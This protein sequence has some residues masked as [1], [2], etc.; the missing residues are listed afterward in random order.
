[1]LHGVFMHECRN[2]NKIMYIHYIYT[3]VLIYSTVT[4]TV[5]RIRMYVCTYIYVCTYVCMH[6]YLS[7]THVHIK[8]IIGYVPLGPNFSGGNLLKMFDS[9]ISVD[10]VSDNC[11][12]SLG[13]RDASTSTAVILLVVPDLIPVIT[14]AL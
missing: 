9:D 11:D 3:Y 5:V 12:K 7:T 8:Y 1:M 13:W 2:P 14:S 4:P 6:T 10:A